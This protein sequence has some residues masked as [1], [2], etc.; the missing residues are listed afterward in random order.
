MQ[1]GADVSTHVLSRNRNCSG[2]IKETVKSSPNRARNFFDPPDFLLPP[3]LRER[4]QKAYRSNPLLRPG[5]SHP[6]PT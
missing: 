4:G 3:A 5:R 1:D 6:Y 2:L